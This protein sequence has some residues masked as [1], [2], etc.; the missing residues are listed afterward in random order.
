MN[1][2]K[3]SAGNERYGITLTQ[4][5]FNGQTL[6]ALALARARVRAGAAALAQ[7]EQRVIEAVTDAYF[8]VLKAQADARVATRE[9]RLLAD[10]YRQTRAFLRVGK[11][12]LQRN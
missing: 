2:G 10:I 5:L 12:A 8:G 4:P 11:G 6:S 1:M 7:T 3:D 9:Q